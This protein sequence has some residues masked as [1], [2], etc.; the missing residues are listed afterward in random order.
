ML[1]LTGSESR[2]VLDAMGI[3]IFVLRDR[4]PTSQGQPSPLTLR[5]DESDT[6]LQDASDTLTALR[7]VIAETPVSTDRT[8]QSKIA[9]E[10]VESKPETAEM[11]DHDDGAMREEP[12][13]IAFSLVSVITE[14]IQILVELPEWAGGLLDGRMTAILSDLLQVMG[15]S[16]SEA[17]WQYFRWPIE[18]MP[19]QSR[20]AAT[21]ATDAWLHRRWAEM[22]AAEPVMLTSV[23]TLDAAMLTADALMMPAF[24]TLLTDPN[25]KRVLWEQIQSRRHA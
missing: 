16:G 13:A 15:C 18:G 12:E 3:P 21:E 14:E 24:E 17:D 10:L 20:T 5:N 8:A 4:I 19:D 6:T 1:T 25:A 22:Q 11:S 2:K 7:D 9:N 23:S